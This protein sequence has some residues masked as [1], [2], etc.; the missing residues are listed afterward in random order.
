MKR[1]KRWYFAEVYAWNDEKGECEQ[2]G[3]CYPRTLK[4]AKAAFNEY[5]ALN[6]Y[7]VILWQ[8]NDVSHWAM[9]ASFQNTDMGGYTAIAKEKARRE[10]RSAFYAENSDIFEGKEFLK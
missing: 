1:A 9:I 4:E 6:C 8:E 3:R 2:V 7:R 5:L 10:F